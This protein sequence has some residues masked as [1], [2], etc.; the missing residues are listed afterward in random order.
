MET[1]LGQMM[2][3]AAAG[4]FD[5]SGFGAWVKVPGL[6][7]SETNALN[8]LTVDQLHKLAGRVEKALVVAQ[9]RILAASKL[10][11]GDPVE[12]LRHFRGIEKGT[13]GIVIAR[14]DVA[15]ESRYPNDEV[16]VAIVGTGIRWVF[17][18]VLRKHDVA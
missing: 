7:P 6:H 4:E 1:T 5:A 3:Q 9:E 2:Q 15:D 12:T 10:M 14:K 17:P 16:P 11:P 18:N 13:P 8:Y